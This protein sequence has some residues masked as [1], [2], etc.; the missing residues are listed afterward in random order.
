MGHFHVAATL[1]GRPVEVLVD[2]GA[3]CTV[4]SASLARSLGLGLDA[5]T[6]YLATGAELRLDTLVPRLPGV[7]AMDFE[8]INA[9]VL[10]QGSTAVEMILGA[11]VLDGHAAV[12][13]YASQALFL[14]KA[15]EPAH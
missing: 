6:Q 9:A 2:T 5:I 8:H 10:A 14:A 1:N 15:A 7:A 3:S 4:V 11:D 13:D 12:I